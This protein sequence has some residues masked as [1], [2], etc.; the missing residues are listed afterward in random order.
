[1]LALEGV[2]PKTA[3]HK[4]EFCSQNGIRYN[5]TVVYRSMLTAAQNCYDRLDDRARS[6][7]RYIE[8]HSGASKSDLTTAF[9]T[10]NRVL[11][12]CAKEIEKANAAMWAPVTVSDLVNHVL[13]YV[14]WALDHEKVEG[15]GVT[16]PWL[17]KSRGGENC[18][19]MKMVMAK[20]CL[21][22]FTK[23]LV[24]DLPDTSVAKKEFLGVL[25]HFSSYAVFAKTFGTKNGGASSPA[26][27]DDE[28]KTETADGGENPVDDPF[29]KMKEKTAGVAVKLLELLFDLF[30][31]CLDDKLSEFLT[32]D[33]NANKAVC[34]VRWEEWLQTELVE[35][36]RTLSLHRMTV[37]ASEGSEMPAASTRGLK[38]SLSAADDD[39]GRQRPRE[40]DRQGARG[41]LGQ[42]AGAPPPVGVAL[43]HQ[44]RQDDQ[45]A[46]R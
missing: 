29:T 37:P 36:R 26:A 24:L 28:K 33:A 46:P 8:R 25:P 14:A 41:G 31:Q 34:Q 1:M 27:A 20:I 7:L 16:T 9:N 38:R 18:G 11:Q 32:S 42:G 40:G 22:I 4:L 6:T 44:G 2:S 30:S 13:D 3:A 10:L 19:A 21:H 35:I 39:G 23:T 45:G 43:V 12:V 17:E 5:G 15:G